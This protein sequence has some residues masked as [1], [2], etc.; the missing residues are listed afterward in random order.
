[1]LPK[2]N[3]P[4]QLYGTAKTHKCNSIDDIS[5]EN[6]KLRPIIAQSGSYTYNA[7][8]VTA[9]YLKPLCSD[10]DYITRNT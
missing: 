3:Q 4:G 9:D 8:Q 1:M 7:A 2:S 5:L 10:N 6:L